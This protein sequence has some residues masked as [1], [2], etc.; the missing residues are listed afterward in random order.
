MYYIIYIVVYKF[1]CTTMTAQWSQWKCLN[2]F[3]A[4]KG[5]TRQ[6][7]TV[8]SAELTRVSLA[9]PA[10]SLDVSARITSLF[11]IIV[12]GF[13][14]WWAGF[15]QLLKSGAVFSQTVSPPQMAAALGQ[16]SQ[17]CQCFFVKWRQTSFVIIFL[18]LVHSANLLGDVSPKTI[19]H[20]VLMHK[21]S[22]CI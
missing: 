14:L 6:H 20:L 17:V 8:K 3:I 22:G 5:R 21:Q 19:A 10:R 18:G 4:L 11:V 13:R 7:C 9:A 2:N 16:V 12:W 15:E 1:K